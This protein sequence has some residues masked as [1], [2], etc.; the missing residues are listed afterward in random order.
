MVRLL[1]RTLTEDLRLLSLIVRMDGTWSDSDAIRSARQVRLLYSV[2]SYGD[3]VNPP[4]AVLRLDERAM[5]LVIGRGGDREPLGF[6]APTQL[7]VPDPFLSTRHAVMSFQHGQV[8]IRDQLSRNGTWINGQRIIEQPLADGD[9]LEL[10]HTLFCYRVV[11][12]VP[13]SSEV[14]LG[15]VRTLCP[16]VHALV[17]DLERIA[18]SR[19]AVLIL[20][21]TGSGKEMVAEMVHRLSG[22]SGA[23]APIDCG[24]VPD[25]LFEA[26]F[27]GHKRGAFTGADDARPGEIAR[28]DAGSLFLDEV[29]NLSL[30]AQAKLLRVIETGRLTPLGGEPRTVDVRWVAATNRE[31][32]GAADQFRADLL[33][34]LA[35]YVARVPSLRKR[36]EDLGLLTAYFLAEVGAQRASIG[37]TAARRLFCGPFEGNVREL[38][39]ILRT[40]WLL[41]GGETIRSEHLPSH[42][43][44]EEP[45]ARRATT[46]KQD[47]EQ[48][49]EASSGNVVQAARR[50]G[51]TGRQ[52]YRWIEK[53]EIA[54]ARYR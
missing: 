44:A 36:R 47:I 16:E 42:V 46:G 22:R 41:A 7:K 4:I 30:D 11:D 2:L 19:E 1:G 20:G 26:T 9:L 40:A 34:R 15:P 38:R 39:Q 3:L 37:A 8:F 31:L 52:L 24:A 51:T 53:H 32:F 10:G 48:A 50:L 5:P 13:V 25:P 14:R 54:L 21:E 29:G 43:M 45:E 33:R 12:S 17:A 18:P 28:A 35:G 49:L 6:S 27:F 23:L